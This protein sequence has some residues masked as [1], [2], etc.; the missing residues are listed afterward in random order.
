MTTNINRMKLS[1]ADIVHCQTCFPNQQFEAN[2]GKSRNL[3]NNFNMEIKACKLEYEWLNGCYIGVVKSRLSITNLGAQLSKAGISNCVVQPIG[4]HLV[5]LSVKGNASMEKIVSYNCGKLDGSTT[6]QMHYK[7][8]R[9]LDAIATQQFGWQARAVTD[10]IIIAAGD[11]DNVR[12]CA[13]ADLP[14]QASSGVVSGMNV[15]TVGDCNRRSSTVTVSSNQK[16][17]DSAD[18]IMLVKVEEMEK[19]RSEETS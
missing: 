17:S 9:Y 19:P 18:S 4:G 16:V 13:A 8:A 11:E 7:N 1:Y 12:C 14:S 2:R 10:L 3:H 15:G 5:F 6:Q